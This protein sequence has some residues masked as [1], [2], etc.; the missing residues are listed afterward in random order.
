[1][2]AAVDDLFAGAYRAFREADLPTAAARCAAILDVA[3]NSP[4]ALEL[5]GRVCHEAGRADVARHLL[6]AAVA[7]APG[8]ANAHRFLGDAYQELGLRDRALGSFMRAIEICE[9]VLLR[10]PANPSAM[11]IAAIVADR[12]GQSDTAW[13]LVQR[14]RR[15]DPT[16]DEIGLEYATIA[17]ARGLREEATRACVEA[18]DE[19]AVDPIAMGRAAALLRAEFERPDAATYLS[20]LAPAASGRLFFSMTNVALRIPAM[21]VAI[22]LLRRAVR[23]EDRQLHWLVRL[24][25]CLRA[26]GDIFGAID[27]L[28]DALSLDPNDRPVQ[29]ELAQ[30]LRAA[31]RYADRPDEPNGPLLSALRRGQRVAEEHPRSAAVRS[32]LGVVHERLGRL[33][34]AEACQRQAIAL[35]PQLAIAHTSLAQTLLLQGRLPEVPQFA[36][37]GL[38]P[39]G[40][41]GVPWPN[42]VTLNPLLDRI[43][44]QLPRDLPRERTLVYLANMHGVIGH[45]A[46]EPY[47]LRAL[48]GDRFDRIVIMGPGR[49]TAAS[50]PVFDVVTRGFTYVEQK[51]RFVD[52][53]S[54]CHLGVV[55]RGGVTYLL[56]HLMYLIRSLGARSARRWQ[57]FY[58]LSEGEEALGTAARERLGVAPDAKLVVL[59][60]RSG[61][62]KPGLVYHSHR[63][64]NIEN[65]LD[66]IRF[67]VSCGYTVVR[68]G[69]QSM[70]RLPKLGPQVI[71][72]PF[73]RAYDQ[74]LDVY[75]IASCEFMIS[76]H[77]GLCELARGFDRPCLP[78]NVPIRWDPRPPDYEFCAPK[79]YVTTERG[80]RRVLSY[81]EILGR[82]LH[83]CTTDAHF[84]ELGVRLEELEPEVLRAV[85]EEMMARLPTRLPKGKSPRHELFARLAREEAARAMADA[86][87]V[88]TLEDFYGQ[89]CDKMAISE[90][91]CD[92]VPEFLP[93]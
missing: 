41:G 57:A 38:H 77:S 74:F 51:D 70:P 78:L 17:Q 33:A 42:E 9:S 62:T 31:N 48:Y 4:V 82:G 68:I 60:A 59:H 87:R 7:N 30:A 10:D 79:R 12:L 81:E 67:L 64:T 26:S 55:E 21:D 83:R 1:M 93:V 28:L 19:D 14:A 24:G 61:S 11:L 15:L 44:A 69:D 45:L 32:L 84:A 34:E 54:Q 80:R 56:M 43:D 37:S 23:S 75:F 53:L 89:S 63:D 88:A 47:L 71:D 36:G 29:E 49:A 72:L 66:T 40:P 3:P 20:S 27:V 65:Y 85:V 50:G 25:F 6:E 90:A 35:D 86:R 2:T 58:R 91:Y 18:L 76:N 52:D 5:F 39:L 8:R 92:A 73:C 46:S 16:L 22:E 13:C